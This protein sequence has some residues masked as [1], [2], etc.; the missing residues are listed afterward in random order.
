M[1][2]TLRVLLVYR[3][4]LCLPVESR[5]NYRSVYFKIG[6]LSFQYRLAF[7]FDYTVLFHRAWLSMIYRDAVM[8][9]A[10][11]NCLSKHSILEYFQELCGLY[12]LLVCLTGST[13]YLFLFF[14]FYLYSSLYCCVSH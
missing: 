1:G 10:F 14:V 12:A 13:F 3:V 2:R 9:N 11:D 5:I 4:R 6:A 8:C 7:P